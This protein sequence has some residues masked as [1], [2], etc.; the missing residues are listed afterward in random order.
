MMSAYALFLLITLTTSAVAFNVMVDIN[1]MNA[2]EAAAAALLKCDGIWFT[3]ANSPSGINWSQV[4]DDISPPSR[5]AVSE[6]VHCCGPPVCGS[7]Q[8]YPPATGY[9]A[10]PKAG[11]KLFGSFVYDEP[12]CTLNNTELDDLLPAY[13]NRII[14]H[15]RAWFPPHDQDVIDVIDHS[16]A[17]KAEM[18]VAM[19]VVMMLVLVVMV[20]TTTPTRDAGVVGVAFEANP[21]HLFADYFKIPRG[22]AIIQALNHDV[23]VLAGT[24]V[25]QLLQL[26]RQHQAHDEAA[27]R[28]PR[29][30]H[31]LPP[32]AHW[33]A[34]CHLP[35]SLRRLTRCLRQCVIMMLNSSSTH[36]LS[37]AVL[38]N[39]AEWD[40]HVYFFG[41]EKNRS[42][43]LEGGGHRG[44]WG[45]KGGQRV[46]HCHAGS[47]TRETNANSAAASTAPC[48]S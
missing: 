13:N 34:C 36:A 4:V 46:L 23:F 14:V 19:V 20:A 22:V 12:K 5:F 3:S 39:Y 35:L 16:G 21:D 18:V 45:G 24:A 40:T 7:Q 6:D 1:T 15:S 10:A 42:A 33:F 29:R 28:R 8:C 27:G 9:A 32:P 43:A 2:T 30:H 11:C 26:H 41:D 38:A 17:G 48:S 31:E 47:T 37:A 44:G 25:E